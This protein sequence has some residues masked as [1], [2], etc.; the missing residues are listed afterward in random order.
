MRKINLIIYCSLT[1]F[2]NSGCYSEKQNNIKSNDIVNFYKDRLE[3]SKKNRIRYFGNVLETS[4]SA[5]EY[6]KFDE[7]LMQMEDKIKYAIFNDQNEVV[8]GDLFT[9]FKNQKRIDCS[10]W[11]KSRVDIENSIYIVER[12]T[13]ELGQSELCN[14]FFIFDK[15]DIECDKVDKNE[16]NIKW[17]VNSSNFVEDVVICSNEN[18]SI[19]R[20]VSFE[21]SEKS[22]KVKLKENE[23]ICGVIFMKNNTTEIVKLETKQNSK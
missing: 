1:V 21:V 5:N 19:L 17:E 15:I 2:F 10:F 6:Y 4:N 8:F 12:L 18:D 13:H 3:H 20:H 16:Y 14:D 7:I 9:F 23:K 11:K 22:K